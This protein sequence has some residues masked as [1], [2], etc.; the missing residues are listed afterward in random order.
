MIQAHQVVSQVF[1]YAIRHRF[2]ATNP[3]NNIELPS[4]SRSK[5]LALTHD[6]VRKLAEETANAEEAVRHRSDT[7]PSQTSPK[8]LATMVRFLAYT[9]LRFGECVALRVG[10]VDT[11]RRLITVS[12]SITACAA[13]AVWR[14]PPRH[15]PSGSCRY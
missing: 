2:V 12:R 1:A 10:D 9:G 8:A 5:D 11:E 3:A 7:R 13:M 14:V 6:Q 15:M 4:K